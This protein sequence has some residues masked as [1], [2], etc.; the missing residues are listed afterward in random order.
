MSLVFV[1]ML[2]VVII[3]VFVLEQIFGIPG[4]GTLAIRAFSNRDLP[5]LLGVTTVVM[6]VGIFGNLLQDFGYAALDPRVDSME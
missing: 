5:V 3:N 6:F 1:D 4:I 2:G